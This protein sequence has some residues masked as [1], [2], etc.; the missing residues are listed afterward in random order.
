MLQVFFDIPKMLEKADEEEREVIRQ[1]AKAT[2][3]YEKA[4]LEAE[5]LQ[6]RVWTLRAYAKAGRLIDRAIAE[7]DDD[8][9]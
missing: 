1:F 5:I 9:A 4:E 8:A 3:I 7:V 6:S 2:D